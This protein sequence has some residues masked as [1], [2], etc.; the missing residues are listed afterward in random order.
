MKSHNRPSFQP[1][2]ERES[3]RIYRRNLPHWRQDGATYFITIRL[4]DSIPKNVRREIE[5]EKRLWLRARG[6]SYD[7]EHGNWVEKLHTLSSDD[8]FQFHK[9]FNR[10]VQSCL[11]RG[12]G[13]CHLQVPSCIEIVKNKLLSED[14]S[15]YELG[16]FVIMPNHV[17]LLTTP[18]SGEFLEQILKSLKGS[19]AVECNR[20]LGRSGTFWQADSYDHIVRSLEQLLHYRRYIADN[21]RNAG[22][23][24]EDNAYYRADWMDEWFNS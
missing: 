4:A 6:I 23:T 1:F 19:S 14:R 16:D 2:D 21:P 10:R 20:S 15:R 5:Y 9:T 11:D 3:V 12:H 17:H 7:G 13:K 24:I 22:I 8:Q 18:R